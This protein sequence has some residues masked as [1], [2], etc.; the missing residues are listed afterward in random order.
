VLRHVTSPE[1]VRIACEVSGE[2]PPVV[3]VHGAGS[4]RWSFDAVRPLLESSFT[5][6]AIDRRGRGDSTDADEYDLRREYE[7]VA[8][9]VRDAGEGA[10]LMGHSYG[11]LVAAGAARL[12]EDLPRLALYEPPMGGV[13]ADEGTIDRWE[14]LIEE[15]DRDPVVREFLGRIGGYDEPAID[16]MARTQLWEA[17]KRA[18]PT[19]PRELRAE[20]AHRLDREALAA[21]TAPTLLLVGTESPDWA[22]RST[23]AYGEVLPNAETRRLEGQG[24]GANVS[25]PQLLAGELTRFLSK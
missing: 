22:T 16:E 25:A 2:G 10:V 3:L 7:D 12:L 19:L 15:G 5:V 8:A 23:E 18:T 14:R 9:V 21:V 4:A 17:R 11:G 13:L 6:I 24:H 20:L 1:G